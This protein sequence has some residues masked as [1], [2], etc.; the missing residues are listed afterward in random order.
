MR[1]GRGGGGGGVLIERGTYQ[2]S[3]PEKGDVLRGGGLFER[4][5]GA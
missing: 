1:A 2:L 3:S 4:G 5:V